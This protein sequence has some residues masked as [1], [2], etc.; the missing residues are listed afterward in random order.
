MVIK[1][2]SVSCLNATRQWTSCA[3]PTAMCTG[4]RRLWRARC[5]NLPAKMP[6]TPLAAN[7]V[8]VSSGISDNG[9]RTSAALPCPWRMH[10]RTGV[11]MALCWS[12]RRRSSRRVARARGRAPRRHWRP[13][14]KP[15]VYYSKPI[16]YLLLAKKKRPLF[17]RVYY[18]KKK[19]SGAIRVLV[20]VRVWCGVHACTQN[21][22]RPP[23]TR[24]T[25]RRM[26]D[27]YDQ[28]RFE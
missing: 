21:S 25:P 14:L 12:H 23:A 11:R 17:L 22:L 4:C 1:N 5:A 20:R 15:H 13:H 2:T 27:V 6:R 8:D 16:L 28:A 3:Y 26:L 7:A 18:W 9:G 19:K 10:G 24:M